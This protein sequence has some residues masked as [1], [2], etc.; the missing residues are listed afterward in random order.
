[1]HGENALKKCLLA[2]NYCQ[3]SFIQEGLGK[4]LLSPVLNLNY[5]VFLIERYGKCTCNSPGVKTLS[6]P[7]AGGRCWNKC[8]L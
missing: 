2:S 7:I 4:E 1:M 5:F 8:I 6:N 3:Y